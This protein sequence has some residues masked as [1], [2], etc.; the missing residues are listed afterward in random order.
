ML[1]I[2]RKKRWQFSQDNQILK[3]FRY[4]LGEVILIVIGILIALYINNLNEKNKDNERLIINLKRLKSDLASDTVNYNKYMLDLKLRSEAKRTL[5]SNNSYSSLSLDSMIKMVQPFHGA[6]RINTKTYD[7]MDWSAI[8]GD[9]DL[10]ILIEKIQKYYSDV[11][12]RHDSYVEWEQVYTWK[13]S[14]F[15]YYHPEFELSYL[16]SVGENFDYLHSESQR[17]EQLLKE[18]QTV[19]GRNL[20]RMALYRKTWVLNG[21]KTFKDEASHLIEELDAYLDEKDI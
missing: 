11:K 5:L 13:E 19:K 18:L 21:M 10:V 14:E 17:K 6:S 12:E 16:G 7:T 4:A 15:W 8:E 2:F 9:V 20:I 3:Y 1:S